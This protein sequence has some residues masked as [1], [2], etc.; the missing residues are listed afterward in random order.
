MAVA[1]GSTKVP[2]YFIKTST[3]FEMFQVAKSNLR[4]TTETFENSNAKKLNVKQSLLLKKNLV[5]G[6]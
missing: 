6:M 1:Y 3:I 4:K 5:P 2:S